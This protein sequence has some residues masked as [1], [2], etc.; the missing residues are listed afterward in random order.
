[1]RKT[2]FNSSKFHK[3]SE[4]ASGAGQ[5]VSLIIKDFKTAITSPET[6]P[7]IYLCALWSKKLQ[8]L[9]NLVRTRL[10]LKIFPKH[11][12]GFGSLQFYQNLLL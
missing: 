7:S 10:S 5:N 6:K 9:T 4:R 2:T 3:F 8:Y 11:L 1:M 12:T